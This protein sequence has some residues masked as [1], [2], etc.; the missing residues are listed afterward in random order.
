MK[1]YLIAL[2]V[3]ALVACS[4]HA[5]EHAD[6]HGHEHGESE[7]EGAEHG[8]H[9]GRTTIVD[10][11]ATS[12][13]VATRTAGPAT[14][15]EQL[16]LSGTVHADP[17]RVSEVRARFAG[18]VREVLVPP[19]GQVRKGA[20]LAQIQSNESL[21][22]YPLVAPIAGTIVAHHARVGE[23]TG[24]EPLFTIM[25]TSK[26]W[27]EL[28]IFQR[29][30]AAVR[31][32]QKVEVIDLGDRSLASGTID[33][34][35]AIATHGS[36]AVPARVV[37]DNASGALRPGQFVN[38]RVSVAEYRVE[39]AVE[40]EALQKFRDSDVVFEK[41]G[42]TY[43]VRMLELGRSDAKH[44]EVIGGLK[45]G[46]QYVADNSYLIKA[47]IEKSGASHDH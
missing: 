2:C 15:Q 6:E 44:I 11:I 7:A 8:A 12:M 34:L 26:V 33:W 17:T 36:Q 4:N 47:D 5:E 13:G 10:A 37:I 23:A 21:L 27:V 43:E 18:V 28:D 9:E 41:L 46:A 3:L 24:T 30:L 39:L 38:A 29:D 25:D 20:T 42:E 45:P 32:G 14:L 16:E 22:N 31:T 1:K 40:R 19:S 35:G